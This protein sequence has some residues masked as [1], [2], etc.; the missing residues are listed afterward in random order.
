MNA[1]GA[2]IEDTYN[3]IGSEKFRSSCGVKQGSATS[4]SLF[5]CYLDRTVRAVRIFGADDYLGDNHILLLMDDTVL[6]AS[7]REAMQ[8]KLELLYDSAKDIDMIIHTDKSQYLFFIYF[9]LYA[10]NIYHEINTQYTFPVA[11]RDQ[12]SFANIMLCYRDKRLKIKLHIT[13]TLSH[14]HPCVYLGVE[15]PR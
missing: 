4:C 10:S 15:L 3:T 13:I 8:R 9:Y 11:Q 2:S 12:W 6:L 5:T 7:S 1:I 14:F